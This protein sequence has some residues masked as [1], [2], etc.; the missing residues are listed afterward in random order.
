MTVPSV[1]TKAC[2]PPSLSVS[3]FSW[4][5]VFL[6]NELLFNP[7]LWFTNR[8]SVLTRAIRLDFNPHSIR[9]PTQGWKKMKYEWKRRDL[10]ISYPIL[11]L[12]FVWCWDN[13]CYSGN[14]TCNQKMGFFF[15]IWCYFIPTHQCLLLKGVILI[16][17]AEL[18]CFHSAYCLSLSLSLFSIIQE[19]LN[20]LWPRW[21]QGF[22]LVIL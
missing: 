12:I 10:I 21:L 17:T 22:L 7:N 19:H 15:N 18:L 8:M 4:H 20:G 13:A 9:S 5:V 14:M 6:F 16:Y 3:L 2:L 11:A 1:T